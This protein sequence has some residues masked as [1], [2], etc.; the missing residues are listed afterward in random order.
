MAAAME[1][2]R[3]TPH[4]Q[5]WQR[6]GSWRGYGYALLTILCWASTPTVAKLSMT[7]VNGVAATFYANLFAL[8][9]LLL[10][11]RLRNGM[12]MLRKLT[13]PE[14]ALGLGIGSL[15]G[16][17]YYLCYY[18]SFLFINVNAAVA[19]NY[20][21]PLL[22]VL[23]VELGVRRRPPPPHIVAGLAVSFAGAFVIITRGA[24]V[25]WQWNWGVVL[26]VGAASVWGLFSALAQRC[27]FDALLLVTFGSTM[28][29]AI[30]LVIL[31]LGGT[32]PYPGLR[33]LLGFSYLGAVPIALGVVLWLRA[34]ALAEPVHVAGLIYFTPFLAMLIAAR[35]LGEHAGTFLILGAVLI[36]MGNLLPS[37]LLSFGRFTRQTKSPIPNR[38]GPSEG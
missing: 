8:P 24:S 26:A 21:Y 20:L 11:L 27:R 37:V 9:V 30:P 33:C 36:V 2:S 28:G 5:G 19:L 22:T 13:L 4:W 34:L 14:V 18:S 31:G 23:F 16:C 29:T 10:I 15:G 12:E 38:R 1:K 32:I 3:G 7:T 35:A 25:A 17:A 6:N